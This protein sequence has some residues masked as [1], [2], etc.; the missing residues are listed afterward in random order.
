MYPIVSVFLVCCLSL[1]IQSQ[2]LKPT[3]T[4]NGYQSNQDVIYFNDNVATNSNTDT[5]NLQRRDESQRNTQ[6]RQLNAA[7][8]SY[9]QAQ[10]TQQNLFN[11]NYNQ[12]KIVNYP[13]NQY[14]NQNQNQYPY[15]NQLSNQNQNVNYQFLPSQEVQAPHT[16]SLDYYNTRQS[17]P[18]TQQHDE[19]DG[20]NRSSEINA[21]PLTQRNVT[22]DDE[23]KLSMATFFI[24]IN[25]IKVFW[26]ALVFYHISSICLTPK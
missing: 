23:K 5:E 25:M 12:M 2:R 9:L 15:N 14:L 11:Q 10:R 18:K 8:D 6:H 7:S 3:R 21:V 20:I 26:I 1:R 19:T 13:S 22:Q 4:Y 16:S 17:V 24:G